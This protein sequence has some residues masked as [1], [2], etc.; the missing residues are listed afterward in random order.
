MLPTRCWPSSRR[1]S[2]PP[3]PPAGARDVDDDEGRPS[4]RGWTGRD[5]RRGVSTF[6]ADGDGG[7]ARCASWIRRLPAG[8][9]RPRLLSSWTFPSRSDGSWRVRRAV[10]A[11]ALL[12]G[13]RRRRRGPG[14]LLRPHIDGVVGKLKRTKHFGGRGR[15]AAA[16]AVALPAQSRRRRR[17]RYEAALE[18]VVHQARPARRRAPLPRGHAQV[19]LRGVGGGGDCRSSRGRSHLGLDL[20][21]RVRRVLRELDHD[22]VS[23]MAGMWPAAGGLAAL[24]ILML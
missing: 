16:P 5:D 4:S 18:R 2:R 7:I 3:R 1:R 21:V 8:R 15:R 13:G 24:M 22:G 11:R 23:F 12:D 9:S 19:L 17:S 20:G 14:A 10:A 6:F